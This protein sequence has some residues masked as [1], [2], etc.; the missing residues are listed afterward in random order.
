MVLLQG[1]STAVR[2]PASLAPQKKRE[3][4]F[5]PSPSGQ[6]SP[7]CSP[8]PWKTSKQAKKQ[9][10]KQKPKQKVIFPTRSPN[11]EDVKR[12]SWQTSTLRVRQFV[13]PY[14]VPQRNHGASSLPPSGR[15]KRNNPR[16]IPAASS[17][18]RGKRG[19]PHARCGCRSIPALL[20]CGEFPC[21]CL[22]SLYTRNGGERSW[23][24]V[25]YCASV[26][27]LRQEASAK[28][29]IL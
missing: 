6:R 26:K 11:G 19:R 13:T 9:A 10:P 25:I 20:A 16:K 5:T 29:D 28:R 27:S 3:G 2:Q 18:R 12:A 1:L 23:P 21:S 22:N 14:K 17:L 4:V 7:V 24:R 15:G 8:S